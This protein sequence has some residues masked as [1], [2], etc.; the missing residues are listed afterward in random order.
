[1]TALADLTTG[2]PSQSL[3]LAMPLLRITA[4]DD[5]IFGNR[6]GVRRVSEPAQPV[7]SSE[8]QSTPGARSADSADL[9]KTESRNCKRGSPAVSR[10][11]VAARADPNLVYFP[12]P[13][14]L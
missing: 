4:D 11:R 5:S 12:R 3:R 8:N 1:R 7:H 10:F 6:C 9:I 2:K 13:A 14:T